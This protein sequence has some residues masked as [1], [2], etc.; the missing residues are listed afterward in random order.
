MPDEPFQA[1]SGSESDVPQSHTGSLLRP[2]KLKLR[3]QKKPSPS[4]TRRT[5]QSGMHSSHIYGSSPDVNRITNGNNNSTGNVRIRRTS[6]SSGNS[7]RPMSV[8]ESSNLSHS[9]S[10]PQFQNGNS[11]TRHQRST[12]VQPRSAHELDFPG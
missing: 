8:Y 6:N 7:T 1:P 12:S 11:P 3:N 5:S 4:P 9:P 2:N 10:A